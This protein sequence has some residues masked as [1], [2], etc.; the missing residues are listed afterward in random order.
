MLK[1]HTN[2]F[3]GWLKLVWYE[4]G[5]NGRHAVNSAAVV[6]AQAEGRVGCTLCTL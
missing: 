1:S 4:I 3:E 5:Q 6:P 2:G